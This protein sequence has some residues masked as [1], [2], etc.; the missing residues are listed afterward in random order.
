MNHMSMATISYERTA[1]RYN[2]GSYRA[3][4]LRA[5]LRYSVD[6]APRRDHIGLVNLTA[7]SCMNGFLHRTREERC[8]SWTS[9]A[10]TM[11]TSSIQEAANDVRSRRVTSEELVTRCLK[12]LEETE[13]EV[14]AFLSVQGRDAVRVARELD[15]KV[16]QGKPVANR[17]GRSSWMISSCMGCSPWCQYAID[18]KVES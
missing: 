2:S 16:E 15:R 7:S 5:L 3:K 12:R 9:V 17:L 1:S 11:A 14:G 4:S 8:I 6:C 10:P 13:A 18:S